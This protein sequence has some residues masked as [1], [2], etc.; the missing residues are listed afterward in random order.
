MQAR[1][2]RVAHQRA[3]HLRSVLGVTNADLQQRAHRRIRVAA[4]RGCGSGAVDDP[5]D[6]ERSRQGEFSLTSK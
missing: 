3:E 2:D 1:L 4:M 6:A 5:C